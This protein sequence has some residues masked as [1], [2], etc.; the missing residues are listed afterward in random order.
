MTF[1]LPDLKKASLPES[2]INLADDTENWRDEALNFKKRAWRSYL[3]S[4]PEILNAHMSSKKSLPIGI[5]KNGSR[6]TELKS[7]TINDKKFILSNTCAFDSIS[8]VFVAVVNDSKTYKTDFE[9]KKSNLFKKFIVDLSK[10]ISLNSYKVCGE[11]KSKI[12]KIVELPSKVLQIQ[13]EN[14]AILLVI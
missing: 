13:C 4:Q 12:S 6:Y 9:F 1:N 3:E 11:L 14:T 10:N 8:Q 7:L 2:S 5:L